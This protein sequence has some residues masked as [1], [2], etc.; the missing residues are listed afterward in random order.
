MG[1]LSRMSTIG[2]K[3]GNKHEDKKLRA[4]RGPSA[5]RRLRASGNGKRGGSPVMEEDRIYPGAN[6]DREV[7]SPYSCNEIR[8][9]RSTRPSRRGAIA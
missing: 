8:S 5:R 4:G 9:D 2:G 1:M 7:E 3:E 6:C